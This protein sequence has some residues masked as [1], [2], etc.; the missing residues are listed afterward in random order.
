MLWLNSKCSVVNG[1]HLAIVCSPCGTCEGAND[2][3][4]CCGLNGRCLVNS[5]SCSKSCNGCYIVIRSIFIFIET[6]S[7]SFCCSN[8]FVQSGVVVSGDVTRHK[9]EVVYF[10]ERGIAAILTL[11]VAGLD[12]HI[13]YSVKCEDDIYSITH[14]FIT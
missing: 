5:L 4:K 13:A 12:D 6:E 14:G 10:D 3:I 11:C 9:S 2:S 8:S 7:L 1:I